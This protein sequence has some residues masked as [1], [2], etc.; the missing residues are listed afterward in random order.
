MKRRM[1]EAGGLGLLAMGMFAALALAT[2][3]PGDPSFNSAAPGEPKNLLG[4]A[5]ASIADTLVQTLGLAAARP[6]AATGNRRSL[7]HN[8][9]GAR[10][11]R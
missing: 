3:A 4:Y 5:G 7:S 6:S 2:Y 1:S 11:R 9:R 10:L 8:R